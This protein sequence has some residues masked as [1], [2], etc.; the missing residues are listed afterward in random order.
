MPV[1]DDL[2][3]FVQDDEQKSLDT[4]GIRSE[5][6]PVHDHRHLRRHTGSEGESAVT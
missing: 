5:G 4:M 1:D 6:S 2:N 3:T